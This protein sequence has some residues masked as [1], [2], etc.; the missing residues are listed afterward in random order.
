MDGY[1]YQ[2]IEIEEVRIAPKHEVTYGD[3]LNNINRVVRD[4]RKI[5]GDVS[6]DKLPVVITYESS[7]QTVTLLSNRTS[8]I[9]VQISYAT[10]R[11][12]YVYDHSAKYVVTVNNF[13]NNIESSTSSIGLL[14]IEANTYILLSIHAYIQDSLR[15]L[16]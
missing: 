7:G 4:F 10:G 13:D 12:S 14:P 11:L 16:G 15:L 3:M 1:T 9:T 6:D 5:H 8:T 2:N